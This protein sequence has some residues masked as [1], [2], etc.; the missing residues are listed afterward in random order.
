M[1]ELHT[2]GHSS[3]PAAHFLG[4][5][6][7]ARIEVLVDTRSAPYSRYSPQFDREALRDAVTAANI[8]YLYL[9]DAVG[10]R[11]KDETHYDDQGRARYARMVH[12]EAFLEAIARLERGA[13]EF[14]VALMCSEE[15]PAHC[16]RRL[17]VG[18][19]LVE[20]GAHL[21]HIRGDGTVQ[22]EEQVAAA[23][24]KPLVEPQPALFTELDEDKWRSTA[25]VSPRNQRPSSSGR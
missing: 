1:R 12:S 6:Q 14:R 20:R 17:L 5:L 10:G 16:H 23:S 4:L 9:G 2:I 18:R 11:P 7:Q 3:H 21:L 15:D 13:E 22:T 24:G 25:S 8:K 19:V